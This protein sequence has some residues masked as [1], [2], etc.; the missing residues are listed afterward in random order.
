MND[1]G[2]T[3]IALEVNSVMESVEFYEK[4]ASF[5]LIHGRKDSK[6]NEY[7]AWLSDGITPFVLVIWNSNK[8][9][10]IL[11]P[12]SHLGVGV[13]S[14]EL[15]DQLI[16]QAKCEGYHTSDAIDAGGVIGYFATITDPSGHQLE[17]SYGQNIQKTFKA[18]ST[19]KVNF[20][21]VGEE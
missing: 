20:I 10:P 14:R 1:I 18:R 21:E 13:K 7:V 15:V 11:G 17:I 16:T 9:T 3:H 4:Y 2:F 5:K 12:K 8:P 6:R 19:S